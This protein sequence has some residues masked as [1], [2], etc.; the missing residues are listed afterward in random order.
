MYLSHRLLYVCVNG[1]NSIS[2]SVVCGV[3]QG[4]I[5]GP[6]LILLYVNDRPN[7]SSITYFLMI[8]TFISPVE[9]FIIPFGWHGGLSRSVG[10]TKI[11]CIATDVL[12]RTDFHFH[13][14]VV[15]RLSKYTQDLRS[16]TIWPINRADKSYRVNRPLTDVKEIPVMKLA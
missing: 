10:P 9:T 15:H 8:L 6:P 13:E 11:R 5:L 14:S 1:H 3:P 2:G 7:S 12:N 16:D 4:S